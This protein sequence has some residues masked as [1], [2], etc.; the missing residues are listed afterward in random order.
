MHTIPGKTGSGAVV[1]KARFSN[2][3]GETPTPHVPSTWTL[4]KG[5]AIRHKSSLALM[6]AAAPTTGSRRPWAR[7]RLHSITQSKE[8]GTTR[9][10]SVRVARFAG[11][12]R[13][14]PSPYRI[15][16]G[17]EG[18]T[19]VAGFRRG[20]EQL[21]Q[22]DLWSAFNVVMTFK[23]GITLGV[24]PPIRPKGPRFTRST[25]RD[26]SEASSRTVKT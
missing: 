17:K 5:P 26:K 15:A 10:P 18:I 11:G 4:P 9:S 23:I 24:G 25:S 19:A 12:R 16:A 1:G 21:L 22:G 8:P 3:H 14:N 2:V 20:P 13:L 7:W 6:Q